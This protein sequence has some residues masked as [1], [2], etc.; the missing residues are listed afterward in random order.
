[1][2]KIITLG[3]LLSLISCV[4]IPEKH[5]IEERSSETVQNLPKEKDMM[6]RKIDCIEKFHKLGKKHVNQLGACK[7]AFGRE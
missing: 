3:I 4:T 2:K 7:F 1:M 6:D 5:I